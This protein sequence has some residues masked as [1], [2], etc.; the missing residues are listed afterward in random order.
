MA[1]YI[2]FDAIDKFI[3]IPNKNKNS[4]IQEEEVTIIYEYLE[5]EQKEIPISKE[6]KTRA[7]PASKEIDSVKYELIMNMVETILTANEEIDDK[8]G[9]GRALQNTNVALSLAF[10]TLVEFGILKEN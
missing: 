9:M 10:T 1:Y 3:T 4:I 8:I 7:F 2:D 5:S 6:V